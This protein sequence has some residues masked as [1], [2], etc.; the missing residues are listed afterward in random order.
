MTLILHHGSQRQK[1]EEN[2][3]WHKSKGA[4]AL[5]Q[6]SP[7]RRQ[8]KQQLLEGVNAEKIVLIP[9]WHWNYPV[10]FKKMLMPGYHSQR[11]W[12]NWSRVWPGCQKFKSFP[13]ESNVQLKAENQCPRGKTLL[14]LILFVSVCYSTPF[15]RVFFPSILAKV[16][17]A[18]AQMGSAHWW[19][20]EV[21]FSSPGC[22]LLPSIPGTGPH[23]P[24]LQPL[25]W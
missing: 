16:A 10:S 12:F 22:A 11:F 20:Q 3:R 17:Y 6:G 5:M 24:R 9:G 4:H 8:E 13:Q 21:E 1:N 25:S 19:C 7:E 14:F 23:P 2:M 18:R 15:L